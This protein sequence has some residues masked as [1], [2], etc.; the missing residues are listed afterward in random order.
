VNEKAR[1]NR[2]SASS[3]QTAATV[4]Y[5]STVRASSRDLAES[6]KKLPPGEVVGRYVV[7][8]LPAKVA[9]VRC[10]RRATRASTASSR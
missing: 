1:E 5:G 2:D 7:G 8:E 4:Q 9:W 10:S 3:I 6:G